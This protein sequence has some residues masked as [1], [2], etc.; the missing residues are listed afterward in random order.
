MVDYGLGNLRAFE[1][2]Y[3]KLGLRVKIAKDSTAIE[4]AEVLILPGVG[5]FD[6]AM[7]KLNK[8]GMRSA[9]EDKALKQRTPILGV[10][11]GM[12][13][14]AE[15]SEEGQMSGFGWIEGKVRKLRM[16]SEEGGVRKAIGGWPLT[17]GGPKAKS[18]RLKTS[19][20]VESTGELI[21]PHMGWNNVEPAGRS[22]LFDEIEKPQFYF[23]HSYYFVPSDPI[24]TLGETEYGIRFCSAVGKGNIYGVQFHP[25]KSHGWG[26]QLLKNFVEKC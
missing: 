1:H 3:G 24:H 25:E 21:L 14:L 10:C 9:L 11:V 5:S 23:L 17:V 18:E 12:Q 19:R 2:I 26:I 4:V 15:G 13:I 6:W 7:N 22:A 20:S 8:S 16:E